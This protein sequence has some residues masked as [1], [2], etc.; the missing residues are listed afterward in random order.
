MSLADHLAAVARD[1]GVAPAEL[2]AGEIARWE[3]VLPGEGRAEMAASWGMS[4]DELDQV[5]A[6]LAVAA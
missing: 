1:T 2:L 5:E 4:V 6:S 3:M